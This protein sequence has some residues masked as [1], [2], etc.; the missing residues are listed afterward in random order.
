MGH[1]PFTPAWADAF[2]DAI[3]ADAAYRAAAA[4]W[5]WPVALVLDPAPEYGYPDA[6]AV[7]LTLDR[8]HCHAAAVRPA[9]DVSA[10]FVLRAAYA[11]WKAVVTGALDPLVGVSRGLIRVQGS[12]TTLLL[13]ATAASALCHCA[14][15]VATR[16]PDEA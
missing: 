10:P 6:V 9:T 13:H 12:L 11:T 2:R 8:G 7:E 4:K 15:G 5:T 3:A 1:P 14:R 16:F